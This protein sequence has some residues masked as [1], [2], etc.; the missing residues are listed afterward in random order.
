V[1]YILV[2]QH[3]DQDKSNDLSNGYFQDHVVRMFF[4]WHQ[5]PK[6]ILDENRKYLFRN[7]FFFLINIRWSVKHSINVKF[8][9]QSPIPVCFS[10]ILR[11]RPIN[12]SVNE[13]FS[14]NKNKFV[15]LKWIVNFCWF[16]CLFSI[17]IH[18]FDI[19]IVKCSPGSSKVTDCS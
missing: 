19:K 7:T 11:L 3:L 18:S 15:S 4:Y 9:E 2:Y 16:L 13:E 14:L 1:Q 8:A 5:Y 17:W 12:R 6:Q 10:F